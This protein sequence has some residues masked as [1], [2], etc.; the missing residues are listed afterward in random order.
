MLCFIRTV[1]SVILANPVFSNRINSLR[2]PRMAK[3]D[4][5]VQPRISSRYYRLF[6]LTQ[7]TPFVNLSFTNSEYEKVEEVTLFLSK[8]CPIN[9]PSNTTRINQELRETENRYLTAP[10]LSLQR[11]IRE[12]KL[13]K[14]RA[15]KRKKMKQKKSHRSK[16]FALSPYLHISPLHPLY[17]KI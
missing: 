14:Q 15:V 1:E 17:K 4:A 8:Q 2:S 11:Q 12:L 7:S 13:R 5:R 6:V 3:Y 9:M 16:L 10:T